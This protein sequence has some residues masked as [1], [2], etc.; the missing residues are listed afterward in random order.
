MT[1]SVVWQV[2]AA[3]TVLSG[4]LNDGHRTLWFCGWCLLPAHCLHGTR[5]V[6]RCD[7]HEVDASVAAGHAVVPV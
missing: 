6:T 5:P 2:V 1:L 3:L 4:L 7:D